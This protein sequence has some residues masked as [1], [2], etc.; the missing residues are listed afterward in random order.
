MS[1]RRISKPLAYVLSLFVLG[2]AVALPQSLTGN[3]NTPGGGGAVYPVSDETFRVCDNADSTKCAELEAGSITAANTSTL[4]VPQGDG[5]LALL[6]LNQT[7]TGENT[8]SAAGTAAVTISG[9]GSWLRFSGASNTG[10]V[11]FG[12]AAGGRLW[13]QGSMTPDTMQLTTG[14]LGNSIVISEDAD[15][16]VDFAHAQTTNPTVFTQSADGTQVGQFSSL[17]YLG[18]QPSRM[19]VTVDGATTFAL[20]GG[21]ILLQCTGA[22]TINT[23]TGATRAGVVLYIENTDTD[24]TIADDDDATAANAIDLTGA[25]ANDVG[26]VAKVITLIYNGTYW[27]QTAESDN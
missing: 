4:T 13:M 22:E 7:L 6:E 25:A 3:A 18:V 23:I 15:S 11:Y 12:G 2:A 10:G 14:T 27:L 20:T 17:D 24:C 26:A 8:Y 16:S 5:T 1:V 9:S 21:Y 19:T